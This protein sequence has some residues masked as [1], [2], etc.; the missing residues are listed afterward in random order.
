M[1]LTHRCLQFF[2][3][4]SSSRRITLPQLT[5]NTLIL[6]SMCIFQASLSPP[7]N[8]PTLKSMH[9]HKKL[10]QKA[11]KRFAEVEFVS[12]S[13]LVRN[14]ILILNLT[15]L[16]LSYR[17][18]LPL[19]CMFFCF[20]SDASAALSSFPLLIAR[21]TSSAMIRIERDRLAFSQCKWHRKKKQNARWGRFFKKSSFT[22][23]K[24]AD[25]NRHSING[26][27]GMPKKIVA[28]RF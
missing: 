21:F 17:I 5:F 9:L 2:Y 18:L 19:P 6:L 24:R 11:I 22:Q 3:L 23:P 26:W 10:C 27:S 4:C 28:R 8:L 7:Y 16:F 15:R 14:W 13:Y 20:I 25:K 1:C 12:F